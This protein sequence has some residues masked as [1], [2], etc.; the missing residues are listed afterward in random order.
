[1]ANALARSCPQPGCDPVSFRDAVKVWAMIG[2]LSFGGPAGQIALMHRELVEKRRWI[3]EERFL[4]AL[5]YCMLLPGPE[6]QQ[7]ACYIG[8]LMHRTKG[9][10]A[11]GLLFVL[12]GFIAI[13]ILSI[14]YA[15]FLEVPAISGLFFGLKAAVFAVV[16]EAVVRIGKR[17]IQSRIHWAIAGLAFV[18]IFFLAVP[19]PWVIAGAA[20]LGLSTRRFLPQ[21]TGHESLGSVSDFGPSVIETMAQRGELGHTAVSSGRAIRVVVIMGLIWAFPIALCAWLLGA[22]SVWVDQG[23][24]FSQTAVVTFGGAYAVLAYIGQRAVENYGWLL[25]GEMLDGLGLAETTP[26]PLIM[27]VQFVGFLGAYRNSGPLDPLVAGCLGATVTVWVTF[28]PCFLW[29]FLGAPYVEALRGNKA[30]HAALSAITAAV[31]GVILNLSLWFGLH[32]LFGH[33]SERHLGP[34]RLYVPDWA[35]F[36]PAALLW[37]GVA[38]LTLFY[39]RWGLPKTLLICAVGALLWRL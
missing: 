10:V 1:M 30:I 9:G 23:V 15:I 12:P 6:A 20:A 39:L 13:L 8:W 19:F 22:G 11:A 31:V 17:A 18:C 14:L 16:V 36:H 21:R 26:G 3:N 38:V 35:T 32:V 5:N 27:V 24:F 4:H 25:P 7:L 28:A 37:M 2:W 29:I 33:V 34:I